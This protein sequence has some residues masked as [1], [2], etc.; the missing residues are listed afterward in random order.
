M[1]LLRRLAPPCLL[2]LFA[3]MALGASTRIGVTFDEPAHLTA[4]WQYWVHDDYRFQPENGNLPQ[5]LAALPLMLSGTDPKEENST[6]SATAD[7]WWYGRELFFR[8]GHDP[9][10]LLFAGRAMITLLGVALLIAIWRW[11]RGLHGSAGGL[12]S[13]ALA[14]FSPTLLAHSALITSDLAAT[15]GFLLA[16]A[17]AW[18][19]CHCVT[20]GRILAL[21][22]AAGFLAL[23]KFSAVLF[24]PVALLLLVVRL[25]RRA[26]LPWRIGSRAGRLDGWRRGG[27]LLAGGAAALLIAVGC[28]WTAFGWR[29]SAAPIPDQPFAESWSEVLMSTPSPLQEKLADVGGGNFAPGP[30]QHAITFAR[31]HRLLPEAWLYGFAFTTY[32]ARARLTYFAGEFRTEGWWKFFPTAFLLKTTW[33]VLLALIAAVVLAFRQSPAARR[34][35]GYRVMPLVVFAVVYAGFAVTSHLNIGHRHLLPIYPPLFILLGVLALPRRGK[36]SRL[37]LGLLAALVAWQVLEAARTR[38]HYLA[39]FNPLAGGPAHAHRMFVDSSLDWGQSL[40]DLQTWLRQHRGKEPVYLSYFGSDEPARFALEV[41]RIGDAYFDHGRRRTLPPL[42]AGL[43]CISATMLHRVY[44]QVRGPWTPALEQTY[45][46]R[47]HAIAGASPDAPPTTADSEA[48]EQLRFGR[49]CHYLET[50]EPDAVVGRTFLVYR[51]NEAE[52]DAALNQPLP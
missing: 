48:F 10:N 50:Q 19:L 27:A 17:A 38:P 4:G 40:L 36:L 47:A 5:R 44:T 13:L 43:Y 33:P 32:H 51:L 30:V 52:L 35:W 31:D 16:L 24:V 45:W 34:R 26:H 11:S 41:T 6:A 22:F 15:L 8:S 42:S 49:L 28:I 20:L 7:V 29:Y 9:A 12:L 21:G 39:Y 1:L 14:A 25:A 2:V 18:R 46:A 23:A 37:G 3:W